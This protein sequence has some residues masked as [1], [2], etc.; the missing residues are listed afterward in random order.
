MKKKNKQN[1]LPKELQQFEIL[2]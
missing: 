1:L 2:T